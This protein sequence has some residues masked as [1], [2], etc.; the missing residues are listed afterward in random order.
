MIHRDG[1][2]PAHAEPEARTAFALSP[3]VDDAKPQTASSTK[4]LALG[5][6]IGSAAIVAALMFS[7]RLLRRPNPKS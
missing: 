4:M 2:E 5:G 3:G 7:G 1:Q 6:G